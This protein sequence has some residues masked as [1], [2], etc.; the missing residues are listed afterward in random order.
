MADNLYK[1][2]YDLNIL[3]RVWHLAINDSRNHPTRGFVAS[4]PEGYYLEFERFLDHEQNKKL[5]KHLNN[6][7][8]V[9]GAE[10]LRTTITVREFLGLSVGDIVPSE[11]KINQPIGL[12]INK[13][14]KYDARPGLSGKKRA[15]QI[16]DTCDLEA[17]EK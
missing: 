16:T 1:K 5:L 6:I 9:V 15:V 8:A 4:D 14:R 11:L 17:Q 3:R 12:Y 13:R 7:E 2:L 10:L